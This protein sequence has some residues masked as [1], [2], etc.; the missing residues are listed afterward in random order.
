MASS[1]LVRRAS[2]TFF[3]DNKDVTEELLKHIVD[4]EIID[5]L[6][7]TLDEL[8]IKLNNENNRFLTTNW[9]IP[10]GTKNKYYIKT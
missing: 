8:I 6:E 10:K 9:A 5:N 3:I 1:N 4:I 2:P 7:G